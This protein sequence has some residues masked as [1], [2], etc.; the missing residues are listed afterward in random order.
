M[1]HAFRASQILRL[2]LLAVVA[3]ICVTPSYAQKDLQVMVAGPWSY[4]T[5]SV[6]FPGRLLLVAS[7]ISAHH[8]VYILG[9]TSPF[10]P[11]PAP[12]LIQHPGSYALNYAAT[13]ATYSNT[14]NVP[15]VCGASISSPS[16]NVTPILNNSNKANY[17]ISLPIPDGYSTYS[18]PYGSSESE[19]SS[20]PIPDANSAP[21]QVRYTTWMVLH[22]GVKKI[23]KSFQLTGS[24]ST[25]VSSSSGGISIVLGDDGTYDPKCDSVSL[26]SVKERNALWTLKQYARFPKQTA[27]GAQQPG[28]YDFGDCPDSGP[29]FA[30]K[31]SEVM[32]KTWP[33][34]PGSA[35]CHSCQM[36]V[37]NAVSGAT[38]S[39]TVGR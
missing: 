8:S 29:L 30:T 2:A 27:L 3:V 4:V 24:L 33:F 39:S 23:P 9:G 26:E 25:T 17:V 20:A 16:T 7:G 21:P 12:T 6:A 1:M 14:G 35:D 10:P 22:Y 18:G 5:D 15:V 28:Q 34:S 32:P 11:Y 38:V 31:Q 37:N 36:S 19:V 13:P